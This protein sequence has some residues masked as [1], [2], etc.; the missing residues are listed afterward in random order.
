LGKGEGGFNIYLDENLEAALPEFGSG[1]D[2]FHRCRHIR[3]LPDNAW[4][5]THANVA[6]FV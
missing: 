6:E 5:Q 3:S 4:Q 2:T 1:I